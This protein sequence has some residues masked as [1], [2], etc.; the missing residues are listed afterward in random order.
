MT[1]TNIPRHRRNEIKYIVFLT[2]EHS[3][4]I[5]IPV[6]IKRITRSFKN[7]R[8]I[9]YSKQMKKMNITYNQ[10]LNYAETNDACTDY[11][12]DA[13][14]YYIYYND[15]APNIVKSNRYRWNI[16][17]ELG[18]VLL[19]HHINNDKTRIFRNSLSTDEYNILENEADY[20]AQLILVPHVALL[21][22]K[23]NTVNQ[24]RTICK[25]SN[26]ASK[27]RYYEYM[28]W[29]SHI[30]KNDAYDNR[31][32]K[33]YYNFIFKKK[34]KTCNAKLIQRY[35]KFCP[36]CGSKNTLQWGDGEMIYSKLDTYGNGKLKECPN[37]KNEETDIKGDFC[38]ICG[39]NL[40]NKCVNE[41]CK[42]LEVLP[43]N[44][45]YCPLCG[46][47]SSFYQDDLLKAWN[48]NDYQN[49]SD[50]FLNIPDGI[51][52]ELPFN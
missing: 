48:Y 5:S 26:P 12:K 2:L 7:I 34:C 40:I 22:F 29:K 27:R 43:S 41:K 25:I 42:N 30:N 39:Q 21:G 3:H 46:A 51:D 32:F 13:N 1:Q 15:I 38:Q 23:V 28:D 47:Y 11:Y 10:M 17:H 49:S 45:R 52:T 19:R 44:A 6:E 18:H 35:G 36:I 9:S 14:M 20:F 37:C 31:I 50:E 16:A 24:L 33:Y 8:L 4:S